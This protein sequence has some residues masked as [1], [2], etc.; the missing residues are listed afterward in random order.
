[1]KDEAKRKFEDDL[2]IIERVKRAPKE[3]I[4]AAQDAALDAVQQKSIRDAGRTF[5]TSGV[6]SLA[7]SEILKFADE[8]DKHL[9]PEHMPHVPEEVTDALAAGARSALRAKNLT[10]AG[11]TFF[12]SGLKSI[13]KEEMSKISA[14]TPYH[15]KAHVVS[16]FDQMN[17]KYGEDWWDWEPETIRVT[18]DKDFGF[19]VSEDGENLLGALQLVLNTNQA[20]EHWH[21][22]EKV[23]HAFNA[24]V[25]DFSILQP[26]ELDEIALTIDLLRRL[27]PKQEYLSEIPGYIAAVAKNSGVVYLPPDLFAT[28]PDEHIREG[29]TDAQVHLDQLN[30]DL[31]LKARIIPLW[32]AGKD[33]ES[34]DEKIQIGRLREVKDY[35]ESSREKA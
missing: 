10:D 30:N 29:D 4:D 13:A 18:L 32:K 26:L 24:N 8:G 34:L 14:Q 2:G 15:Y 28:G 35:L 19:E 11:K 21:V 22:F 1:M 16:I 7:R 31:G 9:W 12:V 3:V 17:E 6:Q 25:V 33:G 20:H 23:G 5:L 27:R